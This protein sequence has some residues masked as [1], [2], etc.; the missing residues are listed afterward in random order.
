[1]KK[2]IAQKI[3]K[4]TELGYDAMAGK[5]S[6]TRKYFWRGLEFIADYAKKGD[7]SPASVLAAQITFI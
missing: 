1:M 4:E 5:F 6:E 3:L 7:K 2:E